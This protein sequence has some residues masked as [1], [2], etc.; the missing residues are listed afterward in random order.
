[1]LCNH[2]AI[3]VAEYVVRILQAV[4]PNQ[5]QDEAIVILHALTRSLAE[6]ATSA[7]DFPFTEQSDEWRQKTNELDAAIMEFTKDWCRKNVA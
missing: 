1:M 4:K 5:Q 7:F 6:V 2:Q 3:R